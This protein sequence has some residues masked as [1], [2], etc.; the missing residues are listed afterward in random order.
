MVIEQL[1]SQLTKANQ[2][3]S[4]FMVPKNPI[5]QS[6]MTNYSNPDVGNWF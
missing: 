3:R 1:K 2:N 6:A 4:I 5:I